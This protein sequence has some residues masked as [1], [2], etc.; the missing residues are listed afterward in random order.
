M[1]IS[2]RLAPKT[3]LAL[4]RYCRTHG[5]TKT[6]ALER[7]IALLLRSEEQ[8]AKHPALIAFERLRE[9]KSSVTARRPS[10]ESTAAIKRHLDAK[11]SR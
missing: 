1:A 8:R 4:Q 10:Q 2:A 11:Y 3:Q 5:V 7:G 6:E 9:Q